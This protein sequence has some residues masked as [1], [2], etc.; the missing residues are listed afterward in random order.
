MK[1]Q[2]VDI[3]NSPSED[4][5]HLD[6]YTLDAAK[7]MPA[8]RIRPMVIICPGGAYAWT[9]K[10]EGEPIAMK[11]LAEGIHAAILWYSV[12]PAVFPTAVTEVASSIYY[13]RTH[14]DELHVD[15]NR[16]FVS[17]FS[18]G[19]HLAASFGCF[20]NCGFLRDSL[21]LTE[22][23]SAWLRPNGLILAYP[24]IT[25]GEKTHAESIAN[26]M[27]SD[28]KT[29]KCDAAKEITARAKENLLSQ[30]I[31]D[32]SGK[33]DGA[34]DAEAF[35]RA[36]SLEYQVTSDTPETFIWHTR[37]DGAVPVENT[38]LFVNALQAHDIGYELHIYPMGGHGV[39]LANELT[40]TGDGN[41]FYPVIQNWIT[42]ACR[43][44]KT[45]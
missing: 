7:E 29:L 31:P 28:D 24:V 19:G 43:W 4:Y 26:L 27:G 44:V 13:I 12:K 20:W 45:R 37:T 17:G 18:A 14:A 42:D 10:R 22:S 35:K 30:G 15:M 32:K 40:D 9:S 34:P 25:S 36:L 1:V 5:A 11:F 33:A 21:K 23:K 2:T 6:I 38:L 8:S 16:V 41:G 39:S 3:R